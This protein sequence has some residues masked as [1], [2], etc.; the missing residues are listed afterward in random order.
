MK[1][2]AVLLSV[3][4][5][6]IA[7]VVFAGDKEKTILRVK[8]IHCASCVSMVKKTVKKVDGV[9]DASVSLESGKVTVVFDP[10]KKPME[11]VVKAINKMGYKVVDGDSTGSADKG[12]CK[13]EAEE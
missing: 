1:P 10:A 5:F 2:A 8:G 7:S 11:N 9:E 3:L 6:L 4:T 13:S 12:C